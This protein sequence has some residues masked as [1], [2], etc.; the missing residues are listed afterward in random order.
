[1]NDR[2]AQWL[3]WNS[4]YDGDPEELGSLPTGA[5]MDDDEVLESLRE[6]EEHDR[7]RRDWLDSKGWM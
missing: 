5:S 7:Q 4:M 2:N 1:M 6:R 3:A